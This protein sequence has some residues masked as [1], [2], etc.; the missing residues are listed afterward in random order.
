MSPNP[1]MGS[2]RL[3]PSPENG[4]PY[5]DNQHVAVCIQANMRGSWIYTV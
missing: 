1:I 3:S 2:L 5:D 4:L